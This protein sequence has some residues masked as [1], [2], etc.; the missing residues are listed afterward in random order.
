MLAAIRRASSL[1]SV[2]VAH[3]KA[4]VLLFN[5]PGRREAAVIH[6]AFASQPRISPWCMARYRN[7]FL[8]TEHRTSCMR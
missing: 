3:D 8:E 6:N 2:A 5:G 7:I 4:G 1:L